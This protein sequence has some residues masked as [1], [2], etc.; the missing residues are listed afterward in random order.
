MLMNGGMLANVL[1]PNKLRLL[2]STESENDI[3]ICECKFYRSGECTDGL[4][5][6]EGEEEGV[7]NVG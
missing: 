1:R 7:E 4:E 3:L 6:S 5:F 2:G